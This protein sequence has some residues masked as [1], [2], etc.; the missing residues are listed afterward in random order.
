MA[1]SSS[2]INRQRRVSVRIGTYRAFIFRLAREL[3]V[4]RRRFDVTLIDDREAERL[5]RL[6]RKKAAPTDVLSFPWN[7]PAEATSGTVRAAKEFAG[8]LGDIVISVE[9][10][11]RNARQEKHSLETEIQQLIL[12]GLLHLL[13]HD[14]EIDDGE[15]NRLEL[16]LR[17]RLGIEGRKSPADSRTS[18][19][20]RA[21]RV[22]TRSTR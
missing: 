13:G 9:A 16:K 11:R 20:R 22:H 19:S 10:A 18:F 7:D 12:H 14:H 2:I 15:M 21:A 5:N 3:H 1:A 17:R 8:F 6:F 4:A